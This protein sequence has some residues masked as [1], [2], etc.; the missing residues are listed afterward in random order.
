MKPKKGK[1]AWSNNGTS[2]FY[3]IRIFSPTLVI[4]YKANS[5][6]FISSQYFKEFCQG[7]LILG[8]CNKMKPLS[9]LQKLG[10]ENVPAIHQR[11]NWNLHNKA[12]TNLYWNIL[13]RFKSSKPS[14]LYFSFKTELTQS[15]CKNWIDF[16]LLIF[17]SSLLGEMYF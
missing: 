8:E 12:W 5:K 10:Y 7:R 9:L 11:E 13:M 4:T 2:H 1:L 6:F 17:A 14:Y 15:T 16:Y 3:I